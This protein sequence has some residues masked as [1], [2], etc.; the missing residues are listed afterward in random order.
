MIRSHARALGAVLAIAVFPVSASAH[1]VPGILDF[2]NELPLLRT[3]TGGPIPNGSAG[4]DGVGFPIDPRDLVDS[5]TGRAKVFH[6]HFGFGPG[7]SSGFDGTV[8]FCVFKGNDSASCSP[9]GPIQP[10]LPVLYTNAAGDY[11]VTID[12]ARVTSN[13]LGSDDLGTIG[14][15]DWIYAYVVINDEG[16]SGPR[17]SDPITASFVSFSPA[18]RRVAS[19]LPAAPGARGLTIGGLG[20]VEPTSGN[21]NTTNPESVTASLP[22]GFEARFSRQNGGDGCIPDV[23]DRLSPPFDCSSGI[24]ACTSNPMFFTSAFGPGVCT[25]THLGGGTT[26][27]ASNVAIGPLSYPNVDCVALRV[28][29]L[30][31]PGLSVDVGDMVQ[32]DVDLAN[33]APP[34]PPPYLG[35][36]IPGG[37]AREPLRLSI[38]ASGGRISGLS[39]AQQIC[40]DLDSRTASQSFTGTFEGPGPA[41]VG[42][43]LASESPYA[44]G[45]TS[46]FDSTAPGYAGRFVVNREA[47]PGDPSDDCSVIVPSDT[48]CRGGNVNAG[49][50]FVVD[51]L[52][53]NDSPGIGS[54]RRLEVSATAPMTISMNAPPSNASGPAPFV[55]WVWRGQPSAD[56]IR[57]LPFGTGFSCMPTP[58]DRFGTPQPFLVANTIG[59]SRRLGVNNWS[60]PLRPAPSRLLNTSMGIRASGTFFLQGLI[61]D[62]AALNAQAAVTNGILLVSH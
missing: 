1:D 35:S 42:V 48:D 17:G 19:D 49:A 41:L 43:S 51:V 54:D 36:T 29:N 16:D 32:I 5:A 34:T 46:P 6:E 62:E 7:A 21:P 24:D 60:R 38:T 53:V 12:F 57:S 30:S 55:M 18:L 33:P 27:A 10:P 23:R 14:N 9:R 15:D 52:F 37:T 22:D 26:L 39:L 59:S 3:S 58:L 50:G 11:S 56:T 20:D 45:P 47:A 40:I 13:A 31:R 8:V 4:F 25:M 44:A 28:Q 2:S 61:L